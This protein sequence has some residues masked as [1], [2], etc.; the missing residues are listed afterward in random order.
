MRDMHSN[1]MD[2]GVSIMYRSY[3]LRCLLLALWFCLQM[4]NVGAFSAVPA[5]SRQ[6]A[7]Q[8]L[9]SPML[10]PVRGVLF[11]LEGA[12]VDTNAVH[13]QAYQRAMAAVPSMSKIVSQKTQVLKRMVATHATSSSMRQRQ[14]GEDDTVLRA[15]APTATANELR[16]VRSL[17][18]QA[19]AELRETLL[20]KP[21]RG[22]Q[23][24]VR[25]LRRHAV[26]IAVV[27]DS[28]IGEA[29]EILDAIGVGD[30]GAAIVAPTHHTAW[31]PDATPYLAAL[32]ALR[33]RQQGGGNPE[34]KAEDCLAFDGSLEGVASATQ[35]GIPAIG[36][37]TSHNGDE[38]IQ[39][40]ATLAVQ[41]FAQSYLWQYLACRLDL[42]ENED[43][44]LEVD[45]NDDDESDDYDD[46]G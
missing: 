44:E 26:P 4:F 14:G 28:S 3:L 35:A 5:L 9:A 11:H 37:T 27:T 12:V 32:Q 10:R 18:D 21:V 22:F 2:G 8:K 39:A 15:L 6:E 30:V 34:L 1:A 16:L 20:K 36:V 19:Y 43:L 40:G 41:H 25:L 45:I 7:L 46:G 33:Q 17:K 42:G 24:F 23:S 38:L 13:V 29:E 31:F